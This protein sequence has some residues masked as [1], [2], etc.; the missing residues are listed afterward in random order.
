MAPDAYASVA[1]EYDA[2]YVGGYWEVYDAVTLETAARVLPSSG[3]RILDAGAGTGKFALR[4]LE[5]GHAVTLLD[6]SAKMLEEAR[7]KIEAAG[8]SKA[9]EFVVGDISKMDLPTGSFD[10]VFCEGDPL[11]YCRDNHRDAAREILRVLRPG[12]GFYVSCDSKWWTA[13]LQFANDEVEAGLHVVDT[14]AARDR[15][16]IPVRTFEPR[17]L[18]EIFEGA[19]AHAVEI[20]A[21][22]TL[23]SFLGKEKLAA[24]LADPASRRRLIE[25]E[26]RASREPTLAGIG[27]HL[28]V[29]GRKPGGSA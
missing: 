8:L 1:Q 25:L 9:A 29:L 7:R 4:F 24:T 16:G 22:V 2:G 15:Y 6:P 26:L 23:T 18:R 14:A 21:K 28:Q 13:L 27:G 20:A 12:G 17:E 19:G 3:G 11:S 10:A 5:A